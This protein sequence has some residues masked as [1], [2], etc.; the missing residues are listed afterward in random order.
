METFSVTN[1]KVSEL[2]PGDIFYHFGKWNKYEDYHP[3]W[4]TD[5]LVKNDML[6]VKVDL[7]KLK[8]INNN[9]ILSD[10]DRY[11][12]EKY[13]SLNW[14]DN[15]HKKTQLAISLIDMLTRRINKAESI[16]D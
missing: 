5:S 13:Y 15:S 12:I 2:Q 14:T 1:K 7:S 8:H 11:E 4:Y 6:M 16:N 10:E 9:N 3:T